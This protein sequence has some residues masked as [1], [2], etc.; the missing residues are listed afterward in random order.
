M[1]DGG[2]ATLLQENLEVGAAEAQ[3]PETEEQLLDRFAALEPAAFRN[4]CCGVCR[5][6]A[7]TRRMIDQRGA[8]L[9]LPHGERPRSTG[10][11]LPTDLVVWPE[12]PAPFKEGDPAFRVAVGTL[13]REMGVP[14]IVGSIGDGPAA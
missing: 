3:P 13:A 7:D 1:T 6:P 8:M 14:V 10:A 12:S 9:K 11:F 5:R 2:T 4:A